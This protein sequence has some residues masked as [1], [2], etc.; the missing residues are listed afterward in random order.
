[1][2]SGGTG[3]PLLNFSGSRIAYSFCCLPRF[4]VRRNAE[5][6]PPLPKDHEVLITHAVDTARKSINARLPR[7]RYKPLRLG[8]SVFEY[9]VLDAHSRS[10]G[11]NTDPII[12][13]LYTA[14]AG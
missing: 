8:R 3:S 4:L 7:Q 9:D 14:K 6:Q 11:D 12:V 5:S 10:P 2:S 13:P 1:M